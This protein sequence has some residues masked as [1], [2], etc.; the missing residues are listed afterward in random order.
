MSQYW[1]VQKKT[2]TFLLN[3]CMIFVLSNQKYCKTLRMSDTTNIPEYILN[4][5][6]FNILNLVA[7]D[8]Y[9]KEKM[10]RSRQVQFCPWGQACL[11]QK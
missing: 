6:N 10:K 3:L 11:Y 8:F 1:S 2:N 9:Q 5:T 7:F 4:L